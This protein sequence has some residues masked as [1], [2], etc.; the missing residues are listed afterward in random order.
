MSLPPLNAIHRDLHDENPDRAPR[1][2][3]LLATG[4]CLLVVLF[5]SLA[6]AKAAAAR[7]SERLSLRGLKR[8]YDP[9]TGRLRRH[10]DS[11]G[12]KAG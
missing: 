8:D 5:W 10:A 1:L 12:R 2:L 11:L 7:P 6:P 9:A 3:D 4:F